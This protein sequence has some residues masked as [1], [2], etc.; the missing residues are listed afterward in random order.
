MHLVNRSTSDQDFF[1]FHDADGT[2]SGRHPP[3]FFEVLGSACL[4]SCFS[5]TRLCFI[6]QKKALLAPVVK[7]EGLTGVSAWT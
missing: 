3:F 1:F 4:S 2:L 7:T 6:R 5:V